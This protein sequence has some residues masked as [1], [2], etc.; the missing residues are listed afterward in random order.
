MVN[1]GPVSVLYQQKLKYQ[2]IYGC[3]FEDIY[4]KQCTVG[5]V[6]ILFYYTI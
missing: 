2:L 5:S 3:I 6:L 4:R 1:G